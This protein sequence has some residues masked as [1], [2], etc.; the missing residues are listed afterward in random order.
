MY[1]LTIMKWSFSV[2]SHTSCHNSCSPA[3]AAKLHASHD[4]VSQLYGQFWRM[5]HGVLRK[6]YILLNYVSLIWCSVA[7]FCKKK[8]NKTVF[9]LEFIFNVAIDTFTLVKNKSTPSASGEVFA[10]LLF[11]LLRSKLGTHPAHPDTE[12]HVR[13]TAATPNYLQFLSVVTSYKAVIPAQR[14]MVSKKS[15]AGTGS[16]RSMDW[17][18]KKDC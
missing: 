5:Y 7:I 2:F 6:R 17:P 10:L 11:L 9:Y 13:H 14:K 15:T 4:Y 18:E 3:P 16:L 1:F 12:L 8:Q